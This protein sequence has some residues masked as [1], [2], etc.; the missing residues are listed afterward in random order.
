MDTENKN[1]IEQNITMIL[2]KQEVN[3]PLQHLPTSCRLIRLN[4]EMVFTE[5]NY[6]MPNEL[7]LRLQ[8]VKRISW[9]IGDLTLK[10]LWEEKITPRYVTEMIKSLDTFNINKFHLA[11]DL[12][13]VF[14]IEIHQSIQ[15]AGLLAVS[16]FPGPQ[17]E[18]PSGIGYRDP[19]EMRTLFYLTPQLLTPQENKAYIF[20]VPIRAHHMHYFNDFGNKGQ[21]LK[22]VYGTIRLQVV[23][24]LSTVSETTALPIQ[25]SRRFGKWIPQRITGRKQL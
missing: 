6:L 1:V 14:Q 13:I 12:S 17:F 8:K 24:P 10:T 23:S 11:S 21:L 4:D 5:Q 15:H 22:Y 25:I 16:W 20:E 2:P 7:P 19:D 3:L 18:L 9:A